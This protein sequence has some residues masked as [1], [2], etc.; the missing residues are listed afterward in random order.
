MAIEH[1]SNAHQSR[2][3]KQPN[4]YG[5][6]IERAWHKLHV[7]IAG[8]SRASNVQRAH[9]TSIDIC[10]VLRIEQSTRKQQLL[11]LRRTRI[12]RAATD[13]RLSIKQAPN[14]HRAR[15]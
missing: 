5:A 6:N 8:A 2:T 14:A 9:Q 11:C 3:E 7:S 13:N 10:I 1:T 12:E 4:H 15:I